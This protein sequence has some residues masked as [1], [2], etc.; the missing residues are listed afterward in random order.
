MAGKVICSRINY[1]KIK[2]TENNIEQERIVNDF[3]WNI[4]KQHERKNKDNVNDSMIIVNFII[5]YILERRRH[6]LKNL[7]ILSIY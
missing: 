1:C 7:I 5:K 2:I 3:K 6:K 4:E